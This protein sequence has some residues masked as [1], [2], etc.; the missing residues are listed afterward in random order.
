MHARVL[1]SCSQ[2]SRQ[3]IYLELTTGF[4]FVLNTIVTVVNVDSI[5][6]RMHQT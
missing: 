3:L 2:N 1:K 6:L 5:S 4:F